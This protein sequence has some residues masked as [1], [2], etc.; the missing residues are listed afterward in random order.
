MLFFTEINTAL[1]ASTIAELNKI[2]LDD[3]R[4]K[5]RSTVAR[6]KS[7]PAKNPRPR[8]KQ[9]QKQ[10]VET[11]SEEKNNLDLVEN[12]PIESTILE[13]DNITTPVQLRTAENTVSHLTSSDYVQRDVFYISQGNQ[14][15]RIGKHDYISSFYIF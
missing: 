4:K 8:T 13:E 10:S 1:Q 9:K 12:N 6:E 7:L 3:L 15:S 2:N 5:K 14:E 11:I